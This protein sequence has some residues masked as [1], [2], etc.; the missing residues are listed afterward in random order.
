MRHV[1]GV[2]FFLLSSVAAVAAQESIKIGYPSTSYTT[3]PIITAIRNGFFGQEG[4]QVELIRMAANISIISLVNNQVEFVTAQGSVVRGAARG[5]PIKSV[6]VIADRP[7]YYLV[8]R[9]NLS[10]INALRG[11]TIGLN[12]LGGS[13]H[14]MTR[15]LLAHYRLDPD[16]DVTI[17]VSGDHRSS[18]ESANVGRTDATVVSVP[19]QSVAKKVGLKVV[20][21]YGEVLQMPLGGLGASDDYI[22]KKGDTVRR[23]LR[24]TLK[25][26]GFIRQKE[27]KRAVIKIMADWFG[28]DS[29]TAADSYDQMILAYP[30]NGRTS[31]EVLEK[32]LEISRQL[33]AIK[34]T[35]PLSRVVDFRILEQVTRELGLK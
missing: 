1:L 25:G 35:V 16:K 22:Q 28:V 21:Y 18:I 14:L 6:A 23:V 24:A 15:E 12:S 30:P 27:N 8:A 33:G 26:I 5:L 4:L 19:W 17:I 2:L 11:K 29:D 31:T 20:A 34:G 32:D 9:G 13:L 10:S 3:L 7:V